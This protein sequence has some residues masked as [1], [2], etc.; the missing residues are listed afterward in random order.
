M[1][2]TQ[3]LSFTRLDYISMLAALGNLAVSLYPG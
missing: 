1:M 2:E 3:A